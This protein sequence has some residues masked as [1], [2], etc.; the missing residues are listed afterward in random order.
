MYP[1]RRASASMRL[2]LPCRVEVIAND[3]T[4]NLRV[5]SST[6][7]PQLASLRTQDDSEDV[8]HESRTFECMLARRGCA[9]EEKAIIIRRQWHK[10]V[11]AGVGQ[12][13]AAPTRSLSESAI[14][15]QP[16]RWNSWRRPRRDEIWCPWR[17]RDDALLRLEPCWGCSLLV[18][19]RECQTA[20]GEN[21][22]ELW[23]HR[24]EP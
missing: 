8:V 22:R 24:V 9:A 18:D 5:S 2:G 4:E 12:R 11:C 14:P 7:R 10:T 19:G 21:G 20:G 23:R 17:G 3:S 16:S 13:G 1:R 15:S 6:E